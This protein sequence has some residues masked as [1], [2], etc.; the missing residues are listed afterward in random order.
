MT[1]KTAAQL[2]IRDLHSRYTDAVWRKDA[3]A[4]ADC[5]TEDAEWR[6]VG[7]VMRGRDVIRQSWQKMMAPSNRVLITRASPILEI[8]DGVASGRTYITEHCALVDGRGALNIGIYF[9]RFVELDD[10]WRFSW[11][12]FELQYA[13]PADMTGP[14]FANPDLGAPPAM[15]RLDALPADHTGGGSKLL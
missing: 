12:L 1:D 7:K 15:P 8:G 14:V 6:I 13:G 5:F 11:R 3:D 9:E 10:R 2:A 4:F